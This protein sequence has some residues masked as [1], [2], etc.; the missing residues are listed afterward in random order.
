MFSYKKTN[1]QIYNKGTTVQTADTKYWRQLGEPVLIKEFGAIDYIDFSP[2]APY[3]FAATCSVRVQIYNPM[4]KLVVKNISTFQ[5]SA[6]GGSFRQDGQLLVAGDE[7]ARIRLFDVS[8]KTVLRTFG[9]HRAPVHRTFFTSDMLHLASFS[10][11]KTVRLWDISTEKQMN[12]F[13]EHTDYVRAGA[14]NP[15]SPD[16]ILSGGY[17]QVVKMYDTRSNQC[18]L[19]VKHGSPVE[20]LLLYPSGGIF[21]SAG[22]TD[23]KIWDAVAG[24]R[25]LAKL[26]SHSKTV[27]CVKLASNG[28]RLMSGSIDRHVKFYDTTN[29]QQIH[30][31]DF[32]SSVLSL[33]IA[34]DNNT[35][36]VGTVDGVL[37]VHNRDRKIDKEMK[38]QR[39][40]KKR[41]ALAYQTDE[42]IV[43]QNKYEKNDVHD[44]LLRK[45]EYSKAMDYVMSRKISIK[46]P[47]ISIAVI[48]E[49]LHRKGL[50]RAYADRTQESLARIIT[51]FNKYIS[52]NRFTRVILDAINVFLNV[53]QESFHELTPEIQK[54]VVELGNR[55]KKEEEMT[56]SFLNLQGALEMILAA[57]AVDD[58]DEDGIDKSLMVASENAKASAVIKLY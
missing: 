45:F 30:Q 20:S 54:L 37:A 56:F 33:G 19:T 16:T 2:V 44:M 39:K 25:L 49:L 17:D 43:N 42:V 29:Y 11:D 35:L 27:T 32:S 28:R 36:V 12:Q 24:G 34:R 40:S 14:V 10:D 5:K 13:T 50:E 4:T 38:K 48:Q 7:E 26:S 41:A 53:Y 58:Q 52:D 18:V 9:G 46:T 51:F 23:I 22:G 3:N 6:Y 21:V 15:V 31:L 1:V 55:V 8:T 57:S 47:E